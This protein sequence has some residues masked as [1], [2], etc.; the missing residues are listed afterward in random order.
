LSQ[1]W[2]SATPQEL[3]AVRGVCLDIDDTLST[4]GKLTQEAYAALWKLKDAG[5]KVVPITGRP[6][7]WCDHFSRFW[8]VDAIVGENGAFTFFMQGGVR[9]RIDTPCSV[10]PA[11]GK[12]KLAALGEKI[13]KRFPHA[14]WAS[15]QAYREFDLAVDFCEDVPAWP[16]ADVEALLQLCQA[17]G[18]H[19]KL[20]SIHVNT[21]FGDYDKRTGFQHW[22]KSGAPGASA[23]IPE[24]DEW[25][26]IGDSPNDEPM[27]KAFRF[28]VGVANLR[29]YLGR[30][31]AHPRWITSAESGA[32][33]AEMADRLADIVRS[34]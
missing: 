27:F 28:S 24:A 10:T 11:E 33:F 18:A 19:A 26:F 16:E 5:L 30:I 25:L 9:K 2:S 3:A 7:G 21:W 14:K 29:P 22:L 17:E 20:S 32:G 6:A 8:P 1:N 15:D 13:R 34:R 12:R 31:Q 4:R 23:P